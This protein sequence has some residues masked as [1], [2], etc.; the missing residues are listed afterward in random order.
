MQKKRSA[1]WRHFAEEGE[2]KVAC[3][4]CHKRLTKHGN[5]SM[6]LRHLRGKHPELM[7]CLLIDSEGPGNDD[8]WNVDEGQVDEVVETL[9]QMDPSGQWGANSFHSCVLNI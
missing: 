4:T 9:P 1:V 2:N 6:M 5:T 8:S 7:H 3:R